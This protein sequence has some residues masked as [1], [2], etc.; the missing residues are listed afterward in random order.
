MF[1]QTVGRV[2]GLQAQVSTSLSHFFRNAYEC[3]QAELI[4]RHFEHQLNYSYNGK[5]VNC[6]AIVSIFNSFQLTIYSTFYLSIGEADVWNLLLNL[7]E[8]VSALS[9]LVTAPISVENASV[10]EKQQ[11]SV[12]AIFQF[13]WL[14]Q[15]YDFLTV[16]QRKIVSTICNSCSPVDT[17]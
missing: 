16:R 6:S 10:I 7:G 15:R 17:S 3:F 5:N 8:Y 1:D 14:I 2:D 12:N 11:S 13:Q 4:R 9:V